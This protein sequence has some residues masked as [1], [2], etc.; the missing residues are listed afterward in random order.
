MIGRILLRGAVLT[1]LAL[2]LQLAGAQDAS[3]QLKYCKFCDSTGSIATCSTSNPPVLL[4]CESVFL[5]TLCMGCEI[6]TTDLRSGQTLEGAPVLGDA[7]EELSPA[8][9]RIIGDPLGG[10]RWAVRAGCDG[11]ILMRTSPLEYDRAM[12]EAAG[13]IIL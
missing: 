1:M 12:R 9:M 2:S 6:Q 13:A 4:L 10:E 8:Q 3:A 11:A 7:L 5:W